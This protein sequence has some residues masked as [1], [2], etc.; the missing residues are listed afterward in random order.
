MSDSP[1]EEPPIEEEEKLL[2]QKSNFKNF[3]GF[4]TVQDIKEIYELKKLIGSGSYGSVYE[5]VNKQTNEPCAV[6]M[7]VK[8]GEENEGW[9][10]LM[11]QELEMLQTLNHPNL[12]RVLDLCEDDENIYIISELIEN[13]DMQKVMEERI[14]QKNPLTENEIARWIW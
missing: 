6:K 13:G 14:N 12:V 5:A 10:I 11:R 1:K 3:R 9:H 2:Q 7:I 4:H 8:E